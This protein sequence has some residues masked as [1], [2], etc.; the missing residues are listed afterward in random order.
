VG[1]DD[2]NNVVTVEFK[3]A[4]TKPDGTAGIASLTVPLLTIV[5]VPFIR[6]Q[7]MTIDF[8]FKIHQVESKDVSK[9]K[10]ASLNTSAGAQIGGFGAKTELKASISK[11][12]DIK[13]N[14]EKS[15]TLKIQVRA[16]QDEMPAGLQEVLDMLKAATTEK[17]A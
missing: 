4:K 7:D 17:V 11:K 5:N 13:S 12:E 8:E 15:A 14:L 9:T 3:Y 1:F 6:V 16:A 2:N 10:N